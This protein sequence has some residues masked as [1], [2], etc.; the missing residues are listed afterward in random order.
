[1][2]TILST[3][4]VA[5]APSREQLLRAERQR[6]VLTHLKFIGMFRE[7]EKIDV[8]NMRTESATIFTP[9]KR[10]LL[11]E[12]RETTLLFLSSTIDRS[13]EIIFSHA[14]SERLSDR[15][16]CKNVGQDLHRAIAGLR[17]LQKTYKDDKLFWCNVEILVE[18]ILNRLQD[19]STQFPTIFEEKNVAEE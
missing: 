14:L 15:L 5:L 19:I 18:T 17:N 3:L 7:G 6:E 10:M 1:M 12:S 13:F 9:L 2:N 16:C 4:K 8:R 11:G